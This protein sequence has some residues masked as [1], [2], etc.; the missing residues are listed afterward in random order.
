MLRTQEEMAENRERA[1]AIYREEIKPQLQESDHGRLIAIDAD[2]GTWAIS[3][4]YE[5]VKLLKQK[6][7]A[8]YP[9][10]LLHPR[11]WLYSVGWAGREP[12]G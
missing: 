5:V 6:A 4:G 3:D 8:K 1:L 10:I 9:F 7:E 11:V 2:T 12:K